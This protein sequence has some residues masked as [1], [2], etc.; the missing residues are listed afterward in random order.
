[1]LGAFDQKIRSAIERVAEAHQELQQQRHRVALGVRIEQRHHLASE[2]VQ[3]IG[4]SAPAILSPLPACLVVL[5]VC[6]VVPA[7]RILVGEIFAACR[8]RRWSVVT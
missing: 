5:L 1:M 3:R 7:R 4:M 6:A 2:P 8:S